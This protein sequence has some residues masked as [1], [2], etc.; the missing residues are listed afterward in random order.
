MLRDPSVIS[1]YSLGSQRPSYPK[2][3]RDFRPPA[4]AVLTREIRL[5]KE[6][7]RA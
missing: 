5:G 2:A 4:Y 3:R 1:I 6:E 7:A